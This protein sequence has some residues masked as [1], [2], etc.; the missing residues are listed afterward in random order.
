MVCETFTIVPSIESDCP[1][2]ICYTLDQYT[3]NSSISLGLSNIT[4]DLQPG[5]HTLETPLLVGDICSFTMSGS[6]SRITTLVCIEDFGFTAT[7]FVRLGGINFINCGG[8]APSRYNIIINNIVAARLSVGTFI[9]ENSSFTSNERLYI[10]STNSVLIANSSFTRSPNGTLSILNSIVTIKNSVFIDNFMTVTS[11]YKV[12]PGVISIHRSSMMI[13][14][15]I[16]MNNHNNMYPSSSPQV[17]FRARATVI[18][19]T[20]GENHTLTIVNS[21]FINNSGRFIGAVHSSLRSLAI[22]GCIFSD[23]V[24]YSIAGA[25]SVEGRTVLISQSMF[26]NNNNIDYSISSSGGAIKASI[27]PKNGSMTIHQSTFINNNSSGAVVD[28]KL[29]NFTSSMT[30][31]EES[32]F[33]GNTGGHRGGVLSVEGFSSQ[34]FTIRRSTF[35]NNKAELG[36]SAL[37]VDGSLNLIIIEQN[38]FAN[39]SCQA[40]EHMIFEHRNHSYESNLVITDNLFVNNSA[41]SCGSAIYGYHSQLFRDFVS[42]HSYN[43][44]LESNMISFNGD[45]DGLPIHGA[46]LCFYNANISI[47]HNNFSHNSGGRNG[48]L[49]SLEYSMVEIEQSTLR[50]GYAERE[51]GAIYASDSHVKISNSTIEHNRAGRRGGAIGIY[52]GS[53]DIKDT[54]IRN[55]SGILFGGTVLAC[56]SEVSLS[57][58]SFTVTSVYGLGEC[59]QYNRASSYSCYS[60]ILSI[61]MPLLIIMCYFH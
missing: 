29:E 49:L 38:T 50:F 40:V 18:H 9:L 10:E 17:T 12:N 4:L 39:N 58:H 15:S 13:E 43:V 22:L 60:F 30:L 36:V 16:F 25:L 52:K 53:L 8:P 24:G 61:I 59:I 46:L 32:S 57:S 45:N 14:N 37:S 26:L 31:V 3:S 1:D 54:S 2:E 48:G 56:D 5:T 42:I 7:E 6:G 51:G 41:S 28:I 11:D 34:S 21:S 55:S 33:R 35:V 27:G 47:L 23:N 44:R 19:A 20:G